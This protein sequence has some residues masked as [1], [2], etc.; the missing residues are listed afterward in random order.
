[1]EKPTITLKSGR[2]LEI[3]LPSFTDAS[4]LYK[5]LAAEL[6]KV[7]L[8]FKLGD[9]KSFVSRDIGSLKNVFCQILSSESIEAAVFKCAAGCTLD[10]ERIVRD[11][12]EK[13]EHRRD[14]FPVA[15]EVAKHALAPFFADL[16][17]GSSAPASSPSDAPPQ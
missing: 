10:G 14:W 8:S 16:E 6:I 2:L 17:F 5:V 4:R 13:A 11:S 3:Q 15:Q 12:F 9:L 7:D 1:M